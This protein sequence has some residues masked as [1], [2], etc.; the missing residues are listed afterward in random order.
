MG[1]L[2]IPD[3]SLIIIGFVIKSEAC[4]PLRDFISSQPKS[5]AANQHA[6]AAL[7]C[8]QTKLPVFQPPSLCLLARSSSTCCIIKCAYT[9]TQKQ[10]CGQMKMQTNATQMP[11]F[12]HADG[13]R[14]EHGEYVWHTAELVV[15]R[16]ISTFSKNQ[17]FCVCSYGTVAL[18]IP[19]P[20]F[21]CLKYS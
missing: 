19:R 3:M 14:L 2:H 6:T 12:E 16:I 21:I 18:S 17:H 13:D 10:F 8:R 20:Q 9:Q 15:G 5:Q 4:K 7:K 1:N 11:V